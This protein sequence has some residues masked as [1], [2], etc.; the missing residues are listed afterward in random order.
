[1]A[2][3]RVK[4]IPKPSQVGPAACGTPPAVLATQGRLRMAACTTKRGALWSNG[5]PAGASPPAS[6]T[7]RVLGWLAVGIVLGM[8]NAFA[9]AEQSEPSFLHGVGQVI[10][11]LVFELPKTVL[12]AT[13][14]GPPVVG[15]AIGLLAGAA[16]AAQ[17]TVGGIVEMSAGFDPW[18]TKRH[19]R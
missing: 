14:E 8:P 13:L 9:A 1:M 3:R 18:G 10:D 11:G 2:L 4:A 12:E 5:R 15:T 17:K 7:S 6:P 19:H 16:R